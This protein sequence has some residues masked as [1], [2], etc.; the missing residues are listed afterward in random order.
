ML[1]KRIGRKVP[2]KDDSSNTGEASKHSTTTAR[3]LKKCKNLN[4]A[5]KHAKPIRA[6]ESR[7]A[8]SLSASRSYIDKCVFNT[9]WCVEHSAAG[10]FH[11]FT[12]AD[13][14]LAANSVA[15]L[16]G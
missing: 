8:L 13:A 11:M 10:S 3:K 4:A 2:S 5:F 15:G 9:R 16:T 6:S 1:F 14:Q 12:S 7:A